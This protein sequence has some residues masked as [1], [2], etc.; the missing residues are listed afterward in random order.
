MSE[1]I[2]KTSDT[3]EAP[4]DEELIAAEGEDTELPPPEEKNEANEINAGNIIGLIMIGLL[5]IF[6]IA[7]IAI[8]A[9]GKKKPSQ[10]NQELDKAGAKTVLEFKEKGSVGYSSSNTEE[11]DE[12]TEV[13][14]EE[15]IN[16]IINNLPA[17]LSLPDQGEPGTAPVV[18]TG[19][20][21]TTYRSDRPDTRNSRSPRKIEGI[22][23][24][25]YTESSSAA[26]TIASALSGGVTRG[27][28]REEYIANQMNLT[29][30]L[31]NS[32][33]GGSGQTAGTNG[34]GPEGSRENFYSSGLGT[35]GAGHYQSP[36][37]IWEGTV[38]SGVLETAINTD[39]PGMVMG[40]VSE[41][42][43]SSQDHKW[44]LIPEG[45]LLIG[46]YN[47]SVSSGQN[48]VQIAWN[49]LIRT[50]GYRVSLGNM[51]G[52]DSRGAA[53]QKASVSNHPFET[54]KAL[55]LIA[56]F[57]VINTE[58][59]N[60]IQNQNNQYLQNALTD[61]YSETA[62]LGNRIL[63][64][65]LDIKPTLKVK[66]GTEIKFITNVPL[67]LPPVEQNEITEKYIRTRK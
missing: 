35:G 23:G 2:I 57:S 6:I 32:M 48:R 59:M 56:V 15:E 21:T 63:D 34:R 58:V 14:K 19:T 33:N 42:V 41:N 36:T 39:N 43:Y 64:R 10:E 24:L 7:F 28:T 38:V 45:S 67:E 5:V 22:G 44:L 55:G 62:R 52:T 31:Q 37:T 17:A 65:A 18:Q 60:D 50:D 11:D 26:S 40:R 29:Q 16:E 66:E 12:D 30:S 20:V 49:T 8:N 3:S 25:P 1:E 51:N 13:Q 47:P 61:V 4:A 53:G 46:E 9:K 27:M 54:L